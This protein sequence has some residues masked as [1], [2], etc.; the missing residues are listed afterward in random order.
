M[1]KPQC[2]NSSAG[3]RLVQDATDGLS[4][5]NRCW[6]D[7][8]GVELNAEC[9][10]ADEPLALATQT[11]EAHRAYAPLIG[12]SRRLRAALNAIAAKSAR[13]AMAERWRV[14]G[15]ATLHE[16]SA[17]PALT[18]GDFALATLTPTPRLV[19]SIESMVQ[20]G[21]AFCFTGVLA[22]VD[23]A[24]AHAAGTVIT[25]HANAAIA[26]EESY[27]PFGEGREF[28][29]GDAVLRPKEAEALCSVSLKP[30]KR[31]KTSDDSI[32]SNE[33]V[34]FCRFVSDPRFGNAF[35]TVLMLLPPEIAT[36]LS[37]AVCRQM[38][39]RCSE[40][41]K[42]YCRIFVRRQEARVMAGHTCITPAYNL[43]A[44]GHANAASGD[45]VAG[46]EAARLTAEA[47]KANVLRLEATAHPLC[48]AD[49]C[50]EDPRQR[51]QQ[52]VE[53]LRTC[54]AMKEGFR[55]QINAPDE[56]KLR[57][58]KHQFQSLTPVDQLRLI[59]D[60]IINRN[61]KVSC[62]AA[63]ITVKHAIMP[64]ETRIA[65]VD[66]PTQLA[67]CQ[68]DLKRASAL[69]DI[70]KHRIR[71]QWA[72][73]TTVMVPNQGSVKFG[74][75]A[76][77]CEITRY[78]CPGGQEV[79]K[80]LSVEDQKRLEPVFR[81]PGTHLRVDTGGGRATTANM[82][83]RALMFTSSS[84]SGSEACLLPTHCFAS[85][86]WDHALHKLQH[87]SES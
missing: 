46:G 57:V 10:I 28:S 51:L 36:L 3:G 24:R 6:F 69:L 56:N 61:Q 30:K 44:D 5:C 75:R 54:A 87:N 43:L 37:T 64:A 86:N 39:L 40:R 73:G 23:I 48:L 65:D 52:A 60:G 12:L 9:T 74:R 66:V 29:S 14:A 18:G 58:V 85:R 84:H 47:M 76:A 63:A 59:T 83:G 22:P 35:S 49:L 80:Q 71:A 82:G 68:Q 78:T 38:R 13:E 79:F 26:D 42:N 55:V 33:N 15:K 16:S 32:G 50:E 41:L 53:T 67:K 34:P 45:D 2:P 4:Y 27:A 8:Y 7:H 62:R 11:L 81:R 1:S 17:R 70:L 31:V 25:R 19:S 20:P 72:E 77:N 21:A